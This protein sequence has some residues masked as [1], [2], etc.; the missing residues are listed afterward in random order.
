MSAAA[1]VLAELGAA[2]RPLRVGVFRALQLGDLLCAVP[3]LRGLRGALP[4]AHITLIGLP[5]AQAF[6]ARYRRYVDHFV[7]FPGYPGLPEQPPD[8]DGYASF[9][10]THRAAPFDLAIQLHGDGRVTNAILADLGARKVAGFC[11]A[12]AVPRGTFL[13]FPTAGSEVRRLL[14]LAAFLGAPADDAALEFP[15]TADD[16]SELADFAFERRLPAGRCICLHPGARA[17]NRRWPPECFAAVGDRLHSATGLPVVLTG[18]SAEQPLTAAVAAA[19]RAPA[20]DAAGPISFGALAAQLSRAAI[21]VTNDTGVSHLA[22]ALRIPSVVIFRA[23]EL[24][25]WAPQDAARHRAVWD[26][27]GERRNEVL[28]QAAEL[29]DRHTPATTGARG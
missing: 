28:Q 18:S 21:V 1:V 27:A 24:D 16:E 8:L 19:M 5:W 26:P 14:A 13:P 2:R 22:A 10:A 9:L 12:D 23:S 6:A 15:L 11:A 20:F 4:G 25:R 29:L 3:A 17:E 7:R